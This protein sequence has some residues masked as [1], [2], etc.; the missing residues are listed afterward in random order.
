[1]A[2]TQV[3]AAEYAAFQK[4]QQANPQ[5]KAGVYW[6][7]VEKYGN[8]EYDA[9]ILL[10]VLPDG[11]TRRVEIK[12]TGWTQE[13][14]DFIPRRGSRPAAG[15]GCYRQRRKARL[16]YYQSADAVADDDR[17]DEKTP[18]E[19][20]DDPRNQTDDAPAPKKRRRKKSS[21]MVAA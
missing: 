20:L 11:Q 12:H 6:L 10:R 21:D 13:L 1:M 5:A 8:P 2:T 7:D 16:A 3:S 4:W 18:A 14:W 9:A 15:N 17:I 19:A